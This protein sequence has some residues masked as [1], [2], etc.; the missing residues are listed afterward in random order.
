MR[1]HATA[2]E[3]KKWK[4]KLLH[5]TDE[6]FADDED[7]SSA[8]SSAAVV[9]DNTSSFGADSVPDDANDPQLEMH[10]FQDPQVYLS[11]LFKTLRH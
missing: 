8:A 10:N 4:Y 6:M 5:L 11:H 9:G 1:L 2:R 3:R 7:T